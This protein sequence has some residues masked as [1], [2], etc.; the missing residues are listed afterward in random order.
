MYIY[1]SN[2]MSSSLYLVLPL[3]SIHIFSC[4]LI[5][6]LINHVILEFLQCRVFLIL[7]IVVHI[8]YQPNTGPLYISDSWPTI[9]IATK[10][11]CI[12]VKTPRIYGQCC[13]FAW[14]ST[15]PVPNLHAWELLT[16]VIDTE[17][18]KTV[19]I[20]GLS[21]DT[22]TLILVENH[23]VTHITRLKYWNNV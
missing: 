1:I 16:Y 2:D 13:K 3:F 9:L 17:S 8:T 12:S 7:H 18:A 10:T 21:I 19:S 20:F 5:E 14:L 6:C 15:I 23:L 11:W 22:K 4:S